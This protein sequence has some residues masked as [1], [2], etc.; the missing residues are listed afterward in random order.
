[1]ASASSLLSEEQ[2]LCPI[3]LDVFTSP[4]TTPCGHNFCKDCIHGY[5]HVTSPCQCPMCKQKFGRRP[6]LKVNTFIAEMADQFR[7]SVEIR[8]TA[9]STQDQPQAAQPGEVPCDVCTGTRCKALKSY[10]ERLTSFCEMHLQ[11]HKRVASMK[12]HKLID[13][14]EN[15]DDRVCEKHQRPLE[16]FCRSDQTCL[17]QF[18]TET[19][20]KFHKTVPIEEE[21]GVR[22]TLLGETKGKVQRMIKERLQ[23]VKQIEHSIALRKRGAEREIEHSVQVF[24]TLMRAIEKSQAEFIEEK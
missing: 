1:M 8:A 23:K 6:E 21:S 19:D 20:H 24:T 13:P 9:T 10:L 4:I 12:R 18:C 3:C 5:W 22:K 11:P 15:L 16:L 2:F 17:C 7:R 14:V